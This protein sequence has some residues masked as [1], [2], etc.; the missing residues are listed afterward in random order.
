MFVR[1]GS[2]FVG[3]ASDMLSRASLSDPKAM[4]NFS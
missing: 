1:L 2:C 4:W 3:R